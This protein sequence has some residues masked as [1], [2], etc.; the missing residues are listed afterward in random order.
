MVLLTAGA[1]VGTFQSLYLAALSVVVLIAS[2]AP[3][4]LPTHY[5]LTEQ[6]ISQ[7]RALRTRARAWTDL[8]RLAIGRDAA[9]VS[10]FAR[11]SWLDR[12]RGFI[13]LF[14][15]ADREAV[16]DILETKVGRE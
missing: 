4:L 7:R 6:G 15:G 14:D 5:E 10:P 2:V 13:V 3:F 1:V 9:L 12:Y 16:V 8:R 11:P